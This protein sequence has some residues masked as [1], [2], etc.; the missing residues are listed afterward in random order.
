MA[1]TQNLTGAEMTALWLQYQEAKDA[2]SAAI[3]IQDDGTPETMGAFERAQRA[4]M[5]AHTVDLVGIAI[6]LRALNDTA[7][8]GEIVEGILHD[9]A[10]AGVVLPQR[11]GG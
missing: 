2:F 7:E 9:L 11:S 8:G 4:I 10:A 3:R 1:P 6:K 5:D